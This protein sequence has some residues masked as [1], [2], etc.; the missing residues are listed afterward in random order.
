MLNFLNIYY[1]TS[2]YG[3]K[4]TEAYYLMFDNKYSHVRADDHG[5]GDGEYRRAGIAGRFD[6]GKRND[7]G[8]Y[9]RRE[10]QVQCFCR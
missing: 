4:S 6:P 2:F 1:T 5:Q 8:Y 9:V 3:K 10:W 7:N